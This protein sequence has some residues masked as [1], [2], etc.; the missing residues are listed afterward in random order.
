[1]YTIVLREKAVQWMGSAYRDLVRFP[2]EARR[3]AGYNLGRVQNGLMPL[4]W[5]PMESI[6]PGAYEMRISTDQGDGNVQYRVI[7]VAK[8]EEAVYV[9]HAFDKRSQQTSGHD[10]DVGRVR[11]KQMLQ[12]RRELRQKAIGR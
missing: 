9:L 12:Q 1:M 8:F 4:D 10:V 5:K 7:Y 2:D 6:G 11:Y 3:E